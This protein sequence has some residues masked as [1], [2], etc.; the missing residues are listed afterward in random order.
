MNPAVDRVKQS[1]LNHGVNSEIIFLEQSAHTAEQA[2]Q[3][4]NCDVAQI[5]KSLIFK[6]SQTKQPVLAL[7]SGDKRLDSKKLA[8]LIKEKLE[9]ADADF[10]KQK[11]GF[12]IG[13]VAPIG[14]VEH[15][16]VY[17]DRT[18]LEHEDVWAAAGHPKTVFK[19]KPGKLAEIANAGVVYLTQ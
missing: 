10:V 1:L 7:I 18:L 16:P 17:M 3:A 11:T 4:L 15:F 2:A 8:L 14:A 12:S 13:G 5:V 9:K 6:T 19:I